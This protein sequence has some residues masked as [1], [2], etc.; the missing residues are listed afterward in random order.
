MTQTLS[1]TFHLTL[2]DD[3][4]DTADDGETRQPD[5]GVCLPVSVSVRHRGLVG[6]QLRHTRAMRCLSI[7]EHLIF[8]KNLFDLFVSAVSA[9][10]SDEL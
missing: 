10:G 9:G 3:S 7:E 6:P 4:V 2:S 8:L 5:T 1:I